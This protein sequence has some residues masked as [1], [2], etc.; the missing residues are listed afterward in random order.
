MSLT[1]NIES[2]FYLVSGSLESFQGDKVEDIVI[3]CACLVFLIVLKLFLIDMLQRNIP[4]E[5]SHVSTWFLNLF[6]K[7][8]LL[9]SHNYKIYNG[10]LFHASP[11]LILSVRKHTKLTKPLH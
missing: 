7:S 8:V 9:L 11:E 3:L 1:S 2:K 4:L 6:S 10:D 5:T